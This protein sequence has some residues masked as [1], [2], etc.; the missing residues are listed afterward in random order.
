VDREPSAAERQPESESIIVLAGPG[1]Y[2]P[3]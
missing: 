2:L 3:G 1:T